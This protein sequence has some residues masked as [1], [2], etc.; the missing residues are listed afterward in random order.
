MRAFTRSLAAR[1]HYRIATGDVEGAIDDVV[2]CKRL[3]RH[4]QRQPAV[5][6]HLVGTAIEGIADAIG[7]AASQEFQPT[8]EQ[9]RRFQAGEGKS[10]DAFGMNLLLVTEREQSICWMDPTSELG[11]AIAIE[12]INRQRERGGGIGSPH[13]GG[14]SAGFR[15]A[16]ARFISE[17]IETSLLQDLLDG[18][19]EEHP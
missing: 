9:L 2:T 16:N 7:I 1:V 12:G 15:D 14:V 4:L 18:T 13:P 19:A 6:T 11:E 17:T 8:E 5:L 10:L 3:G